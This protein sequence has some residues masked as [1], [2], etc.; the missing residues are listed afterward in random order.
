MIILY[1]CI[2][3]ERSGINMYTIR[4]HE[5]LK[6]LAGCGWF[7]LGSIRV[8]ITQWTICGRMCKIK[9]NIYACIWLCCD[10]CMWMCY[11]LY[12]H[13]YKYI[14][15][16]FDMRERLNVYHCYF[17]YIYIYIE[18]DIYKD[19]HVYIYDIYM[20]HMSY[21]HLQKCVI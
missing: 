13:I 18:R 5:K 15:R 3:A 20:L 17:W 11:P 9:L 6:L 4:I 8:M 10:T 1:C 21:R 7:L 2:Y 12:I 19:V 16:L 14:Y